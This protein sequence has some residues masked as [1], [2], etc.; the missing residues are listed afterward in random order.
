MAG[1]ND[2]GV[3]D[4]FTKHSYHQN[5]T[6]FYLCQD[7]FPPEKYAKSTSRKAHYIVAFKNPREQ[8][9]KKVSN[10]LSKIQ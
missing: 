5:V 6:V 3:L 8:K 10:V 1:G 2:K 4:L 9:K 7:M